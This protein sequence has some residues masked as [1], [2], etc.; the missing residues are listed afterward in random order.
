M[1][2]KVNLKNPK[3]ASKLDTIP[4]QDYLAQT[5]QDNP[6]IDESKQVVSSF[7][8]A[9]PTKPEV[10]G[11]EQGIGDIGEAYNQGGVLG[12][13][14]Q[15]L[16]S[17][18]KYSQTAQGKNLQAILAGN[19]GDSALAEQYLGEGKTQEVK[20]KAEQDAYKA[21][22]LERS[23]AGMEQFGKAQALKSAEDV[24]KAGRV[25]AADIAEKNRVAEKEN[26]GMTLTAQEKARKAEIAAK[27]KENVAERTAKA[28]EVPLQTAQKDRDWQEKTISN[29]SKQLPAQDVAYLSSLTPKEFN[30]ALS[31]IEERGTIKKS[32]GLNKQKLLQ[33]LAKAKQGTTNTALR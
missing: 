14:G 21:S 5:A 1:A 25:S 33:A 12:A 3:I 13:I 9:E 17:L 18:G 16:G 2:I 22:M 4:S 31:S 29:L 23:K 27:E 7:W 11:I 24:A 26:L 30:L 10:Y 8:G 28:G 20:D 15:G 19:A 32:T 6:L